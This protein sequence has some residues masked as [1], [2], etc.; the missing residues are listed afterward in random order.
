MKELTV[1]LNEVI[2]RFNDDLYERALAQV[3]ADII[4]NYWIIIYAAIL[5]SVVII[6]WYLYNT[7][8]YD[9]DGISLVL[10]ICT[11]V[12]FVLDFLAIGAILELPELL[13]NPEKAALNIMA[14]DIANI[15]ANIGN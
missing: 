3:Q 1:A 9:S 7:K 12:A 5:T 15:I 11:V 8:Y 14:K 13:F 2:T 6:G 4:T 10:A